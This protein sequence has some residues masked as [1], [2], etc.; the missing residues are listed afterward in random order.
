MTEVV[1]TVLYRAG[2]ILLVQT[3]RTVYADEW[4]LPGG[5]VEEEEKENYYTAARRE[6]REETGL[7]LCQAL[8]LFIWDWRYTRHVVLQGINWYGSIA[9]EDTNE[10]RQVQ[11]FPLVNLPKI[12]RWTGAF[13]TLIARNL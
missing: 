9:P 6:L 5:K 3:R 1:R 4:E 13:F 10:I 12:D 2:K 8:P 7:H 11:W